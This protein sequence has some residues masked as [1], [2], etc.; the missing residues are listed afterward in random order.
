M[1]IQASDSPR[2]EP[3]TVVDY[4]DIFEITAA[5]QTGSHFDGNYS[6]GQPV[7]PTGPFS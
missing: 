2:Y 7:P 6:A 4:G 5:S 1:E 3:P